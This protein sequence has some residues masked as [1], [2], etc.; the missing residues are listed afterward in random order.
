M[1]QKI[2]KKH[3]LKYNIFKKIVKK[4]NVLPT[5]FVKN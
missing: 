1:L 2:K 3:N 4:L 5:N